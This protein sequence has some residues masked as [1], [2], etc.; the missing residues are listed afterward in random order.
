MSD[1]DKKVFETVLKQAAAKA[2]NEIA[3]AEAK[4]VDDFSTKYKK[5]VVKSDRAAFAKVFE[6]EHLGASATWDKSMYDQVQAL[7]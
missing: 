1:A 4:L 5:T 7:K 3:A 6:K 2:T